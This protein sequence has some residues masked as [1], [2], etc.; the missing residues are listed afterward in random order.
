MLKVVNPAT[1]AVIRELEE[2]TPPSLRRKFEQALRN[3]R[4]QEYV[5]HSWNGATEPDAFLTHVK[6][7]A[8]AFTSDP[9]ASY[10]SRR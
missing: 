8:E 3:L 5:R 10:P 6:N 7:M 2:D 9:P 1:Y 4:E